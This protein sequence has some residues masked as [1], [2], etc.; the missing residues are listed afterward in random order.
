M[1]G[2]RSTVI[3]GAST[4][5]AAAAFLKTFGVYFLT[6]GD[7]LL[8]SAMI[9]AAVVLVVSGIGVL[10]SFRPGI[11]LSSDGSAEES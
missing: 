3:V 1:S 7:W 2:L 10:R 9:I 8:G 11:S 4:G 6:S 5:F